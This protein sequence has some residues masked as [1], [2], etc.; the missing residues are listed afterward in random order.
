[1]KENTERTGVEFHQCLG[2]QK[3]DALVPVT[4]EGRIAQV[5]ADLG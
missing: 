2:K 3:T 1:V 5:L 4:R